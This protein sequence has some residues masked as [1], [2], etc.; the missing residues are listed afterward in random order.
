MT[1]PLFLVNREDLLDTATVPNNT[2]IVPEYIAKHAIKAMRLSEGEQFW[3]S[4]GHGTRITVEVVDALNAQVRSLSVEKLEIPQ[5]RLGL[6]QALAKNG[7]DEQAIEMATEIGVDE[8]IPWQANR[9]IVQWKGSKADKSLRKW[10]TQINA[11]TEQSRRAIAPLLQQCVTSKLLVKFIEKRTADGHILI[12]LHQDATHTWAEIEHEITQKITQKITP[13]ISDNVNNV[14]D[15]S[16]PRNLII[17]VVVGPEGGISDEELEAFVA[18]GAMST[19]IGKNIL[20]ASSAGSVAL[21][22]L[23]R[24]VGRYG[25]V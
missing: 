11:A 6:V 24:C 10:Q 22:L 23:S 1:L 2:W 3:V 16:S 17:D 20:R 7:R 9:S 21:S 25:E 4:D 14:G 12:I 15:L 5:V 8:V 13:R 19:V 18:A